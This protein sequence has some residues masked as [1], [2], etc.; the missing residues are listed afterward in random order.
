VWIFNGYAGKETVCGKKYPRK[1]ISFRTVMDLA[2]D[3]FDK[4]YCLSLDSSYTSPTVVENL[5]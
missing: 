2:N 3:L 1:K 4:D 5:Q